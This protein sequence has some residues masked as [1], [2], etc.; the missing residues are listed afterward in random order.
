M[1]RD[2]YDND[3]DCDEK[4]D[5]GVD[6]TSNGTQKKPQKISHNIANFQRI[7]KYHPNNIYFIFSFHGATAPSETGLHDHTQTHHTR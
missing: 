7:N 1:P 5:D 2:G 3:H 4:D 6:E